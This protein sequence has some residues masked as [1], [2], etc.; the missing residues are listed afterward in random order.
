[1]MN[2]KCQIS[3]DLSSVLVLDIVMFAPA[4]VELEHSFHTRFASMSQF[5]HGFRPVFSTRTSKFL[6]LALGGIIHLGSP[7]GEGFV[8][9][10]L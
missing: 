8:R 7:E 1:M 5:Q 2:K 6:R 4:R 9:F 3:A 10:S